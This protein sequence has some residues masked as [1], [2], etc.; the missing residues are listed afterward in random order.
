[1]RACASALLFASRRRLSTFSNKST[2]KFPIRSFIIKSLTAST[3]TFAGILYFAVGNYWQQPTH[4]VLGDTRFIR[5]RSLFIS[6]GQALIES[7]K[8]NEKENDLIL[9]SSKVAKWILSSSFALDATGEFISHIQRTDPSISIYYEDDLVAMTSVFISIL[10]YHSKLH[11]TIQSSSHK[12][13][14]QIDPSIWLTLSY[15]ASNPIL[16]NRLDTQLHTLN[17]VARN[18]LGNGFI[19]EE[20]LSAPFAKKQEN[21]ALFSSFYFRPSTSLATFILRVLLRVTGKPQ[22]QEHDGALAISLLG[23]TL[24]QQSPPN[25]FCALHTLGLALLSNSALFANRTKPLFLWSP[26][27]TNIFQT[28]G[29]KIPTQLLSRLEAIDAEKTSQLVSTASFSAASTLSALDFHLSALAVASSLSFSE[30]RSDNIESVPILDNIIISQCVA[31]ATSS[32]INI[33]NDNTGMLRMH[34]FSSETSLKVPLWFGAAAAACAIQKTFL[35]C[36]KDPINFVGEASATAAKL[37]V[38]RVC[39]PLLTS[40]TLELNESTSPN[41][42]MPWWLLPR[43]QI[44]LIH[45]ASR[46]RGNGKGGLDSQLLYGLC[47]E[48]IDTRTTKNRHMIETICALEG[49]SCS[50]LLASAVFQITRNMNNRVSNIE[51]IKS[52]LI[53]PLILQPSQYGSESESEPLPKDLIQSLSGAALT[54]RRFL[55][56]TV[57]VI[58]GENAIINASVVADATISHLFFNTPREEKLFTVTDSQIRKQL[59]MQSTT[60]SAT[61][62]TKGGIISTVSSALGNVLTNVRSVAALASSNSTSTSSE[63]TH[64]SNNVA[65]Y[66]I[67]DDLGP[68]LGTGINMVMSAEEDHNDDN[69]DSGNISDTLPMTR[70]ASWTALVK[71]FSPLLEQHWKTSTL[72]NSSQQILSDPFS[73][74]PTYTSLANTTSKRNNESTFRENESFRYVRPS[75]LDLT[76]AVSREFS[77]IPLLQELSIKTMSSLLSAAESNETRSLSSSEDELLFLHTSIARSW[78]VSSLYSICNQ[79]KQDE[80]LLPEILRISV[81]REFVRWMPRE[82]DMKSAGRAAPSTH[83]IPRSIY[84]LAS[85]RAERNAVSKGSLPPLFSE[86]YNPSSLSLTSSAVSIHTGKALAYLTSGMTPPSSL[87]AESPREIARSISKIL[88]QLRIVE[89]LMALINSSITRMQYRHEEMD[90]KNSCK[91]YIKNETVYRSLSESVEVD[92]IYKDNVALARQCVR[93]L[94]NISLTLDTNEREIVRKQVLSH[95]NTP[96]SLAAMLHS[97]DAKL[98]SHTWR[99]VANLGDILYNTS[100]SNFNFNWKYG[101]MLFPVYQTNASRLEPSAQGIDIVLV[102]GLQGVALKTWRS[103]CKSETSSNVAVLGP[104]ANQSTPFQSEMLANKLISYPPNNLDMHVTVVPEGKDAMSSHPG[105]SNLLTVP[106]TSTLALSNS[107]ASVSSAIKPPKSWRRL[108]LWPVTWLTR[109]LERGDFNYESVKE[110]SLSDLNTAKFDVRVISLTYDAE[111]WGQDGVRPAV[112]HNLTA[113]EALH[114]LEAAGVGSNGRRVIFLSHSMGG[115]LTERILLH[116]SHNAKNVDKNDLEYISP[117]AEATN[118]VVFLG[119]PHSGAPVAEFA[120]QQLARMHRV[121]PVTKSLAFPSH[122]ID[123]LANEGDAERMRLNTAFK[124]LVKLKKG[125]LHVLSLAEGKAADL[126]QAADGVLG[127][128]PLGILIVPPNNASCGI[129]EFHILED[130][131]HVSLSKPKGREHGCY[132]KILSGIEKSLISVQKNVV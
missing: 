49:V 121:L 18:A 90:N 125:S 7:A 76:L 93:L 96:A 8:D 123:V 9:S 97:H 25:K 73:L 132:P 100:S 68:G 15:I 105:N 22:V 129:G 17:E 69:N 48:P 45:A 52:A 111:I 50:L 34:S 57:T 107:P 54:M 66:M 64:S 88:V 128:I 44:W 19:T 65:F 58:D 5:I 63:R 99:L 26:A 53:R 80:F 131:D 91:I 59:Q 103:G 108:G 122:H 14:V 89:P 41:L 115:L 82:M 127:A 24:Q 85:W 43:L 62:E 112:D 74:I 106:N 114:Q 95:K 3:F 35:S 83:L 21:T 126:A 118:M 10:S 37:L 23:C 81:A 86:L 120:V 110:E 60:Q 72:S 33:S 27:V 102:H 109:D 28:I 11:S 84:R 70:G 36:D 32:V 47:T 29:I 51:T 2:F 39:I 13:L 56:P 113:A 92:R 77:S 38:E 4:P 55:N 1:M 16:S 130:E 12:A 104:L 40:Q 124:E 78:L 116:R 101:D 30:E 117:L 94:A 71:R 87:S 67:D 6:L 20:S 31:L 119:T 79:R 61:S 98:S 75:F 42:F 46:S